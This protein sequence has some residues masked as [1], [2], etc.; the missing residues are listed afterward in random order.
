MPWMWDYKNYP[1]G[2]KDEMYGTFYP[3]DLASITQIMHFEAEHQQAKTQRNDM[4]KLMARKK[5]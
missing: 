5:A 4:E 3:E 2:Q 1:D